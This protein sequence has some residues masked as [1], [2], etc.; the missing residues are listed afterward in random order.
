MH[1]WENE[2]A[3]EGGGL[4]GWQQGVRAAAQGQLAGSGLLLHPEPSRRVE[5]LG[6]A[7]MAG[8]AVYW[9]GLAL[10]GGWLGVTHCITNH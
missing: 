4:G 10:R 6:H 7:G 5:E 9:K 3:G 8:H 1:K 2:P